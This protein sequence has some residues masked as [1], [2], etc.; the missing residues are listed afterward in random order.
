[1]TTSNPAPAYA[2]PRLRYTACGGVDVESRIRAILNEC[3][4]A[5]ETALS[6]SL[7]RSVVLLGGYGR[8]E[9]GVV[10]DRDRNGCLVERPHNN[11]DFLVVARRAGDRALIQER[12][13]VA[14]APLIHRHGIG[15]DVGVMA[16]RDLRTAPCLVMWYDM[17]HGHRTLLGDPN[18]VPRLERFT[19][20]GVPAWDI[21]NLL[22]NRGTLLVINGALADARGTEGLSAADARVTIKHAVKA[23]IGYGDAL[24]YFL[25]DYHWSYLE[26]RRRM[27][28]RTDVPGAFRALYDEASGFRLEP[29]YPAWT[30]RD[31]DSWMHDLLATIEPV[32]LTCERLRLGDSTLTW[33]R[34]ATAAFRS[35]LTDGLEHPRGWAR[36]ARALLEPPP[37]T[38]LAGTAARLG[39]RVTRARE[40]LP[41]LFPAVAYAGMPAEFRRIACDLLGCEDEPAALRRAYLRAW[42]VH[43][44][45]NFAAA[46][47]AIGLDLERTPR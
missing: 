43:G 10:R 23:V 46:L 41:L 20:T 26:K 7:Y 24:L 38:R 45:T 40:R 18:F 32:H 13:D 14:L 27:R 35:A 5:L 39:L 36:K 37:A 16:E 42:G 8:G 25:G 1:M 44:D 33:E 22:V 11:L 19:A 9:G 4:E 29:D 28:A 2:D 30:R 17:R 47:R 15:M 34:Y 31:L 3:A 6:S 21:R 12:A